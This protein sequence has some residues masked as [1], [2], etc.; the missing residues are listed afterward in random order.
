MAEYESSIEIEAT[1]EAVFDFLVTDEGMTAWMGQYAELDPR[2]GGNFAVNIA[3]YAVRGQYLEVDRP[4]RVAF[5]WGMIGSAALPPG[6]STV[7]FTLSPTATGTRVNLSHTGLPE[8]E[9]AG[10]VRGWTHFLPRLNMVST[11]ATLGADDW[12]PI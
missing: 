7:T 10:H 12:Q 5:T 2:P 6:A 8:S 1:P 3:G 9:V 4:R 11:G